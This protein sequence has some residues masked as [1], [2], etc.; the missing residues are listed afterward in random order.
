MKGFKKVLIVLMAI[1]LIPIAVACSDEGTP[2]KVSENKPASSSGKTESNAPKVF[3]IGDVVQ[4]K[5][6][7]VTVNG[8]R[9]ATQD[10]SGVIKPED[11]NEYLIV[12]CTV[13][14]ISKE[15]Q[16]IS[17]MLMFK[18][19]DKDGR[20]YDQA[21]MYPDL[22]GSLEGDVAPTRK[23]T[24][25]YAVEVPKGKKGL[26]LVFDGSFLAGGQIIVELR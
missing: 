19:E 4:L 3:K 7:K 17:S 5:D 23:I 22:K 6:F 26:E 14:N 25:E 10:K 21:L 9:T 20:S 16:S 2:Q 13:E 8:I 11:G 15:N 1:V 12:D 18:I 24:G